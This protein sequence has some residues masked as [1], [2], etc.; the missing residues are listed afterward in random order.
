[1]NSRTSSFHQE[2][3]LLLP[4]YVNGTLA[5]EER[6]KVTTHLEDCA[7]CQREMAFLANM[8][9]TANTSDDIYALPESGFTAVMQRIDASESGHARKPEILSS[10]R[11]WAAQF[12]GLH[13][14]RRAAWTAAVVPAIALLVFAGF[15]LWPS[16]ATH[17]P[18]YHTLS[19]P[20]TTDTLPLRFRVKFNASI[21]EAEVQQFVTAI[22]ERIM[23]TRKDGASYILELPAATDPVNAGA[24]LQ[25]LRSSGKVTA[26]EMMLE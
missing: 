17:D 26:V 11:D 23:L 10:A 16:S 19:N 14:L 8:E 9:H 12:F 15:N 3:F 2:I 25:T 5:P 4:W 24:L 6:G 20:Q 22:D 7:A 13:P 1:M 18:A 21:G